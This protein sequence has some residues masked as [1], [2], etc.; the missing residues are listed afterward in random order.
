MRAF[1]SVWARVD[2]CVCVCALKLMSFQ[3]LLCIHFGQKG[4]KERER[5]KNIKRNE[6]K[7]SN[8]LQWY[9]KNNNNRLYCTTFRIENLFFLLLLFNLYIFNNLCSIYRP[10]DILHIWKS[11]ISKD[12][13]RPH[14][15]R[16]LPVDS[17][18]FFSFFFIIIKL[19]L[20][21]GKLI[22]M[23]FFFQQ[24]FLSFYL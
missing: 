8:R 20:L 12:D 10:L 17:F 7:K 13:Y 9:F 18:R 23:I 16:S 1:K 11:E 3:Q 22:R 14:I 15:G 24:L 21:L 6:M 5:R 19:V 2:V 4:G